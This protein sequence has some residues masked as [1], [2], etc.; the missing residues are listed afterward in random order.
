MTTTTRGFLVPPNLCAC[1]SAAALLSRSM[2]PPPLML[3]PAPGCQRLLTVLVVAPR[4]IGVW[5]KK[6]HPKK[7]LGKI[8]LQSANIGGRRAISA[9]GLYI[10]IYI[11]THTHTYMYT[12]IYIYIYVYTY[13]YIYI[14]WE[15]VF[16][17][18]TGIICCA[19]RRAP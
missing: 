17:T 10:C 13:I 9:A 11:H 7:T 15:A 3:L 5:G 4:G 16:F 8:S 14:Y 19:A 2:L 12:Y 6:H 18:D 1:T